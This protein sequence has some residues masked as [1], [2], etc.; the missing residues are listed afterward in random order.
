MADKRQPFPGGPREEVEKPEP[1]QRCATNRDP[2]V[3]AISFPSGILAFLTRERSPT[4][5][6]FFHSAKS[7]EFHG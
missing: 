5:N 2:I 3:R 6:E 7:D 1:G 4:I